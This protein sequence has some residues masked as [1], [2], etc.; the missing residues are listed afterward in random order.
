MKVVHVSFSSTGGAGHVAGLLARKQRD[1]GHEVDEIY[2]TSTNLWENP[3]RNFGT[4]LAAVFDKYIASKTKNVTLFSLL[5]ARL[6]SDKVFESI[7]KSEAHVVHLHWV[8]GVLSIEQIKALS[9]AGKKVVWTLHDMHPLTGGCHHSLECEGYKNQCSNC[10]QIRHVAQKQVEINFKD[11]VHGIASFK[12]ISFVAPSAWMQKRANDSAV[13]EGKRV[14]VIS[15]PI[16]E[17]FITNF[18]N[19]SDLAWVD[20]PNFKVLLVAGDLADPLKN[21][22]ECLRVIEDL[23]K[24]S[25]RKILALL[26]GRNG[27]DFASRFP[28]A[29]YLG[30]LTSDKLASQ[31]TRA[32]VYVSSSLAESFSL[33]TAEALASGLYSIVRAGTAAEELIASNEDGSVFANSEEL[34]Q[35]LKYCLGRDK[36]QQKPKFKDPVWN[37]DR[38]VESYL[39]VYTEPPFMLDA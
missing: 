20:D 3:F 5:R 29:K 18:T 37:L 8:T 24:C 22:E 16:S 9:A 27:K 30:Q 7:L 10:P 34:K 32:D 6:S 25:D 1:L 26:V 21:I 28:S 14:T 23:N 31:M 36:K 2:C 17:A 33:S 13:L 39:Q 38:V 12:G 15:N 4:T 35:Q 11:K 19:G